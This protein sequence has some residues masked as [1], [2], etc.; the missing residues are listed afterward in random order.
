LLID[1]E[2]LGIRIY[3]K[4]Q[5]KEIGTEDIE[6]DGYIVVDID[7]PENVRVEYLS[8]FQILKRKIMSSVYTKSN[9][10]C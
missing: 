8:S 9:N 7:N 1:E 6:I 10:P 4:Q 2:L 5:K 3:L